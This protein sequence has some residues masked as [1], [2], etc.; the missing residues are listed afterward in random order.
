[1]VEFMRVLRLWRRFFLGVVRTS[2][3]VKYILRSRL[4]F[5]SSCHFGIA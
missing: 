2:P 3:A 4:S 5:F 1:M